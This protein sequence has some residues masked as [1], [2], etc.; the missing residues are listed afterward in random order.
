MTDGVQGHTGGAMADTTARNW[1]SIDGISIDF[2]LT[3]EHMNSAAL[4]FMVPA[5][6]AAVVLP[7]DAF[8][9]A[10]M[11]DGQAMLVLALADYVRNP[12]GD[13]NEVNFGLMVHPVGDPESVGA[14]QWRMPVN[15]KFT[16]KAGNDVMGLPKTV[17]VVDFE[18]SDSNVSVNLEMGGEPTLR[19][20]FPRVEPLGDPSTTTTLTYSYLHGKPMKLPLAIDL[21]TGMIDGSKVEIELGT[22]AAAM[23]LASMGLP[24]APDLAMWGEGLCGTFEWPTSLG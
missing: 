8:E 20:T 11:G 24:K 4:S 13:Y 9:V 21:P 7:G 1:G 3:V 16:C 17:E 12:W 6:A 10:D 18:Y 19:I 15:Q 23:E 5:G 14:F 22:S 2:P